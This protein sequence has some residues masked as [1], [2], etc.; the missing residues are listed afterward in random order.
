MAKDAWEYA[1]TVW[2]DMSSKHINGKIC[3]YCQPGKGQEAEGLPGDQA[4]S[5]SL[6][7]MCALVYADLAAY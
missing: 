3:P 6:I 4:F 5:P 2:T 7:L 1:F